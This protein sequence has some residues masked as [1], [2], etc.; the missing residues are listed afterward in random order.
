M[1]EKPQVGEPRPTCQVSSEGPEE[2]VLERVQIQLC[3]W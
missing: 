1:N 2:S 3:S